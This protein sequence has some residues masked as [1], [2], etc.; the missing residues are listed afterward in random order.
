MLSSAHPTRKKPPHRHRHRLGR[1]RGPHHGP[2]FPQVNV[3]AITLVA[4]NV[5]VEQGTRNALFTVEL[6]GSTVPV[7][8]GAA[9][10]LARPLEDASWFHGQD[11]LGDH[12][13]QPATRA[14]EPRFRRRC[15]GAHPSKANP[16]IELITL[17]PLTNLALALHQSPNLAANV[18]RCVVMGGAPC[19]EG[20]VTPAAE[21]NFWVDPEA[22]RGFFA[23]NCPSNS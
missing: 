5:S 4:G 18:S 6:C 22:A 12:G 15:H 9:G 1:R 21:Y 7:F 16:G 13:Y 23:R 8:T 3:L 11:G 10:P 19:C 17:G 14:A 2:A 20:N